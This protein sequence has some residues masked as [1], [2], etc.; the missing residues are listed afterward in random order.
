VP[1]V[2]RT[3]DDVGMVQFIHSVYFL[4]IIIFL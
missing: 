2:A 3:K 1:V 4:A